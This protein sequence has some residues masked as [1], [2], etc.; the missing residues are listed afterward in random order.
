LSSLDSF[1]RRDVDFVVLVQTYDRRGGQ[2]L[3]GVCGLEHDAQI[4]D[5]GKTIKE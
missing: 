2:G 4:V 5:R 3:G 1:G